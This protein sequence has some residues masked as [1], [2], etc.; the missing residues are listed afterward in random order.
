MILC[1]SETDFSIN[2]K[3]TIFVVENDVW[4]LEWILERKEYLA[5]IESFMEISA[6]WPLDGEMPC[7][8][9]IFKRLCLQIWQFLFVNVSD[10][11]KNT[12][13]ADI[14]VSHVT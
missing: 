8:D 5:M 12:S 7:I 6:F 2:F 13:M 1:D 4:W 14:F 9:V 11:L 10:F 3:S